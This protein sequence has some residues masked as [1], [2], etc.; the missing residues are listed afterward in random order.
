MFDKSLVSNTKINVQS[1]VAADGR[2]M[3]YSTVSGIT[4]SEK[5]LLK[6]V[7]LSRGGNKQYRLDQLE[8]HNTS[9]GSWRNR[10]DGTHSEIQ[11]SNY[12]QR[13][14]NDLKAAWAASQEAIAKARTPK[15]VAPVATAKSVFF[16]ANG[17]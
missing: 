1:N 16:A 4:E 14:A 6:T 12:R 7:N 2:I 3:F 13:V 8:A 15:P 11:E 5:S 17:A 9:A 10:N